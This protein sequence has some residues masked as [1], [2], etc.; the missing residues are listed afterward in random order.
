MIE[1]ADT[2]RGFSLEILLCLKEWIGRAHGELTYQ[3]T[4]LLT[5]H[6]CFKGYTHRIGKTEN[7]SFCEHNWEDNVHVLFDCHK[8]REEKE[9]LTLEFEG[10]IESLGAIMRGMAEDPRKWGA[11]LEFS[12]KVMDK[13]EEVKREEQT[14]M[15]RK[16]L[17]RETEE[18]L[19]G[20]RERAGRVASQ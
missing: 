17:I 20:L 18:M 15:R 9:K 2:G 13:K 12:T 4:L 16:R 5:E 8:W 11:M 14:E 19:R 3:A 10:R 1:K 6:G 7:G